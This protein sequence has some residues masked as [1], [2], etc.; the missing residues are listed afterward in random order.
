VAKT[1][2]CNTREND[3]KCVQN[4]VRTL[5]RKRSP[6]RLRVYGRILPK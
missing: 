2:A 4:I 6:D 5:V 3:H 1:R